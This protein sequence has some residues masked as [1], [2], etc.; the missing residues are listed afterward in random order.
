MESEI[1]IMN[2][3]GN[4]FRGNKD[5]LVIN[6]IVFDEQEAIVQ[7]PVLGVGPVGPL[8]FN[9]LSGFLGKRG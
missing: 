5:S 7:L 4:G 9:D 1:L 3:S 6:G 2:L 8:H